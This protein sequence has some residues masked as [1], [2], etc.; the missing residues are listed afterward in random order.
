MAVD[1]FGKISGQARFGEGGSTKH[2]SG[3]PARVSEFIRGVLST[4]THR[5]SS[6]PSPGNVIVQCHPHEIV[7]SKMPI[8]SDTSPVSNVHARPRL[9]WA[10]LPCSK[11]IHLRA[12]G[13]SSGS[14]GCDD[15]PG[16]V[17]RP[18]GRLRGI[19]QVS[20]RS[21][22]DACYSDKHRSCVIACRRVLHFRTCVRVCDC[23]WLGSSILGSYRTGL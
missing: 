11:G 20:D 4:G 17:F 2:S 18:I 7:T 15:L 19:R 23:Y 12:P 14:P 6:L 3:M 5:S 13:S 16:S 10:G 1:D 9:R 22:E 8:K 21:N